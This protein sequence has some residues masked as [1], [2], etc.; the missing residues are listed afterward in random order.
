M[1]SPRNEDAKTRLLRAAAKIVITKGFNDTGLQEILDA[2]RVPKGSFYFYFKNKEDFGLQLID[3]YA[4]FFRR[5][6]LV[7]FSGDEG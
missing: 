5:N 6:A 2:A 4:D 7:L 1:K 3:F